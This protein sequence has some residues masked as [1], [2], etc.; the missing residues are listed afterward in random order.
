MRRAGGRHRHRAAPPARLL[1]AA[2][3]LAL[4]A[5]IGVGSALPASAHDVLTGS[6]PADGSTVSTAPAAITLTF[7][8]PVQNYQ[9][10]LTVTGPN[11]NRFSSGAP[12][13]AGDVVSIAMTGDGPAGNYSAAWRV[14]SAD[15]HP[16]SGQINYTLTAA[17]AGTATGS[18]P[19]AGEAAHGSP[20]SGGSTGL[21]GWLWIGIGVA[22]VLVI[23]A[24]VLILRRPTEA[25]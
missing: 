23:G 3:A 21:G 8:Q 20:G 4:A 25:D 9:P 7:D 5:I 11:G 1:G 19:P 14:V 18:A 22:V 16:V 12:T 10:V 24:V 17:A 6:N 2:V 13:V 15:G